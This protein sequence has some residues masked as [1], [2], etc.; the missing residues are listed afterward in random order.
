MSSSSSSSSRS[1]GSSWSRN[2][3]KLFERALAV[4]DQDTPDRWQ[5][6]ARF[7]GGGKTADEVRRHYQR[8]LEDVQR[9]ESGHVPLPNYRS[10]DDSEEQRMENFHEP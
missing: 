9:I 5:N 6:V 8:L 2:Q 7:V 4:Y 10:S 3:N 1:S